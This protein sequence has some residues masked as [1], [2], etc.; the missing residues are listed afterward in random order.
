MTRCEECGTGLNSTYIRVG[1]ISIFLKKIEFYCERCNL[2]YDLDY[3]NNGK[4][5]TVS[6]RKPYSVLAQSDVKAD[7]SRRA[8]GPAWLR[9]RL[10]MAGLEGSNPFRPTNYTGSYT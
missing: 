2:Y 7:E 5:F 4:Q 9:H 3:A 1:I 10:D 8:G 6:T